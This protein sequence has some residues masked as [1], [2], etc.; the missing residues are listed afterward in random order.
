MAFRLYANNGGTRQIPITCEYAF[1][2]LY[3][4][5]ALHAVAHAD[6]YLICPVRYC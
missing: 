4:I 1:T 5:G 6:G 2:A 3:G